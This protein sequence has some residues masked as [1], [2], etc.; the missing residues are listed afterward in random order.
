MADVKI[1]I[2]TILNESAYAGP[3]HQSPEELQTALVTMLAQ[4]LGLS[5]VEFS[6]SIRFKKVKLSPEYKF[7]EADVQLSDPYCPNIGLTF[8]S[9]TEPTD[10][11]GATGPCKFYLDRIDKTRELAVK[12]NGK[13]FRP[14]EEC[15]ADLLQ[16]IRIENQN[17][18]DYLNDFLMKRMDEVRNELADT[19][20]RMKALG[21]TLSK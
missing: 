21:K 5:P 15:V 4:G 20:Q 13:D 2:K 11:E 19:R 3:Y 12:L 16:V 10:D 8:Y 17:S 18:L 9:F 1:N 14:F 6:Q 7:I